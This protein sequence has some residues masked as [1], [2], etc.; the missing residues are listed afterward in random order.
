MNTRF[1]HFSKAEYSKTGI[2]KSSSGILLQDDN[3][4]SNLFVRVKVSFKYS[5]HLK[6]GKEHDIKMFVLMYSAC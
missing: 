2:A 5:A 6:T 1:L 3:K 4:T